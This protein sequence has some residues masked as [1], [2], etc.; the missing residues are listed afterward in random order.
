[1]MDDVAIGK[2][3]DFQDDCFLLHVADEGYPN[4]HPLMTSY[5]QPQIR[6]RPIIARYLVVSGHVMLFP[7]NIFEST[8]TVMQM[9]I[10]NCCSCATSSMRAIILINHR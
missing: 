4:Q 5:R 7:I 1:M 9:C 6:N 2:N 3:H 10:V 8:R